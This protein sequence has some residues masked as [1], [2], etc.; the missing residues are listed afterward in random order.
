MNRSDLETQICQRYYE[1][2]EEFYFQAHT[3]EVKKTH[4]N[5]QDFYFLFFQLSGMFLNQQNERLQWE[6]IQLKCIL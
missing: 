1:K 5:S 6:T 2:Q 3:V 4:H